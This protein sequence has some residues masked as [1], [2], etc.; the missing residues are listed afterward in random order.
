MRIVRDEL[1][2]PDVI[3]L[4]ELHLRSAFE[5]S[6]PGSVFA[7][8][9]TGLR[10]PAVTLWSVWDG[11]D[12]LGL[13]ALKELDAG[14][15]ELKSMR[16][17]PAHLRRGVAAAMLGHLIA[18]GRARG[19]GRLSLETGSN[20]PFA[21]ARALYEQAGFVPCGPFA[22]YKDTDFSRYYRLEL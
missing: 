6:P 13:G 17:A 2:H 22:A 19:Y 15:G 16:T 14:H 3:A 11:E 1:T 5:N 10:D 8:D 12:L 4:L 7:L 20:P 9:L 21:P 18:E